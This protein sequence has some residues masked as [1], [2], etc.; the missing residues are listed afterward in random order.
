MS[1]TL[2]VRS[3][4]AD[5]LAAVSVISIP[6]ITVA[7]EAGF[8][9]ANIA[10]S[11]QGTSILTFLG[12]SVGTGATIFNSGCARPVAGLLVSA[13]LRRLTCR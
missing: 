13:A 12:I 5:Q 7:V 6:S 4:P 10:A 8:S 1:L 9:V 11:L 2:A 3:L